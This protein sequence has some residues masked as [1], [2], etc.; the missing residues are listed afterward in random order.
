M[1]KRACYLYPK[2]P[3]KWAEFFSV[4]AH[5]YRVSHRSS[6]IKK[7]SQ[8]R[9]FHIT[10]SKF[11][12]NLHEGLKFYWVSF[13]ERNYDTHK[14]TLIENLDASIKRTI[15]IDCNRKSQKIHLISTNGNGNNGKKK[16]HNIIWRKATTCKSIICRLHKTLMIT[17]SLLMNKQHREKCWIFILTFSLFSWWSSANIHLSSKLFV[18]SSQNS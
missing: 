4:F 6:H 17:G 15:K 2:C 3:L 13:H 9:N 10:I 7:A 5:V 14:V 18:S 16:K 1:T 11:Q 8:F 12:H